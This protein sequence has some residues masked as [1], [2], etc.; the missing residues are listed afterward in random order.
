MRVATTLLVP[1]VVVVLGA[2]ADEDRTSPPLDVIA[3]GSCA[4]QE[5][6]QPIWDA[7]VRQVPDLFLFL[8]DNVYADT[9]D[10]ERMRA[11]YARLG[12]QPGYRTLRERCPVLATWDDHDYGRNDAGAEY[13]R[14]RESKEVF[15]DFFGE[16]PESPRR[17]RDGVYEARVLGPEGQRVQFILL[18]TRWFRSPLVRRVRGDP[19]EGSAGPYRPSDDPAATL[20]GD[21]QWRWLEEQVRVPAE[22]RI[23]CSSIQV[24]ASEHG[25]ESWGIFPRER[26]RLLDLVAAAG[27]GVII[28]S[29]DRHHAELSRDDSRGL[30]IYDLTSSSLNHPRSWT[31]ELNAHR[32]GCALFE[33]NFGLLRVDWT[34]EDPAV[35]LEIRRENG[36]VAIRRRVPLRELR[37]PR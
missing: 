30:A 2:A 14:K 12:E 36:E 28:L 29:G 33:A 20:L 18:D 6:P 32:V 8:G 22:L 17:A 16:P 21:E 5:K 15:L 7:I 34:P 26:V 3:F 1:V 4:R 24:L 35:T 9:E 23:L 27:G 31:N 11:A 19:S 10:M 37:A 25:Y 13:P